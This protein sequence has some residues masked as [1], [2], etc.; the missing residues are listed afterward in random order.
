M[1]Q[2]SHEPGAA[3]GFPWWA[4]PRGCGDRLVRPIGTAGCDH[5][6]VTDVRDYVGLVRDVMRTVDWVMVRGLAGRS[7]RGVLQTAA[8]SSEGR[9]QQPGNVHLGTANPF[10]DLRLGEVA[11]EPHGDHPEFPLRQFR[12][13]RP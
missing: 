10:G 7:G 8:H 11:G 9:A 13:Q 12:Q 5:I 3:T 6:A 4:V 1:Y 2:C